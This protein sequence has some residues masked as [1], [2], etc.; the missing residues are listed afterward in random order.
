MQA[1]FPFATFSDSAGVFIDDLHLAVPHDVLVIALIK[2]ERGK[3]LAC[4]F[5]PRPTITPHTAK[6]GRDGGEKFPTPVCQLRCTAV[7]QE[8]IMFSR[9]QRG[10][11]LQRLGL[12]DRLGRVI[13]GGDDQRGA[14]FIDEYA[15]GLIDDREAE[16]GQTQF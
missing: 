6:R 10:G 13:T 15:V 11:H 5:F 4:D 16:P 14:R 9:T 8:F 1:V 12:I 2:V 7:D 3:R